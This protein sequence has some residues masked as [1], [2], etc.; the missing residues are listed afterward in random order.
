MKRR[1]LLAASLGGALT[2]ALAS[3]G[4]AWIR[5]GLSSGRLSADAVEVMTAV[6]SAVLDGCLPNSRA[7][8][9]DA[10][11]A[12]LGRLEGVIS[13]FSAA[14][15]A[16]LSQLLALLSAPPGRM[17]FAGLSG[18]WP[19]ANLGQIQ[20]ALESM[21]LSKLAVRQ[22]AYHALRDLTNAAYFADPQAWPLMGY[23]GPRPL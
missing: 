19:E 8:R 16:E 18:P 7:E 13:A 14:T 23:P 11:T 22:Q 1:S 9:Q 2:L 10:L 5:T 6:G 20:R 12:L 3:D 15:Q 4:V 17:I 21:R